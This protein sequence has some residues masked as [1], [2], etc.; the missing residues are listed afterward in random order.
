MKHFLLLFTACF[1]FA[2]PG[3]AANILESF[4]VTTKNVEVRQFTE[5]SI[6]LRTD[7]NSYFVMLEPNKAG[8]VVFSLSGIGYTTTAKLSN[9]RFGVIITGFHGGE[10]VFPT[11]SF[12]D[13]NKDITLDQ[14]MLIF[15]RIYG[16]IPVWFNEQVDSI[17]LRFSN[18]FAV[19]VCQYLGI[20]DLKVLTNMEIPPNPTFLPRQQN[21]VMIGLDG[22]SSID[23]EERTAIG[24]Q[25]MEFVRKS[26]FTQDSNSL[27]ILEYGS[28]IISVMESSERHALVDALR[29]YTRDRNNKSKYTSWTNWAKVFDEAIHRKPDIFI[30]ITDGWSNWSGNGP[31]SFSAQYES[32][33]ARCNI[34]KKNGTRLLFIT[35]DMDSQKNSKAVLCNFLNLNQTRELQGGTLSPDES[36][37]DVDLITMRGFSNMSDINFSS[38]MM[39]PAEITALMS[40]LGESCYRYLTW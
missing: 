9:L 35:S 34:L 18:S 3:H 16:S 22:S 11:Y 30:F 7:S 26:G 20:Q 39:C 23:K 8:S 6:Q 38:I 27:C 24:Q 21:R 40:T 17:H 31:A 10:E 32:L 29:K 12:D 13:V 37:K 19:N 15:E 36:L 28:D 25:L 14:H 33:I 4:T 1:A 5:S 2:V